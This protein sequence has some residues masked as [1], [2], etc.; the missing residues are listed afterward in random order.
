MLLNSYKKL[1]NSRGCTTLSFLQLSGISTI[2]LNNATGPD[3]FSCTVP[4]KD[5]EKVDIVWVAEGI[6]QFTNFFEA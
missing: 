3:S 5:E 2:L 1:K 4:D 6:L